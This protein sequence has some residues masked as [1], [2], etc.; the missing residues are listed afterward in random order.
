MGAAAQLT[1]TQTF[2]PFGA[3]QIRQGEEMVTQVPPEQLAKELDDLTEVFQVLADA[4]RT[5]LP[6]RVAYEVIREVD[7]R[8]GTRHSRELNFDINIFGLSANIAAFFDYYSG[9]RGR[10]ESA[11]F[12]AID[13]RLSDAGRLYEPK[14]DGWIQ[15]RIERSMKP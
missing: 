12:D 10:E 9:F 15:R 1:R 13:R 7:E 6:A 4:D 2:R 11:M 5:V 3:D 14:Y 8:L